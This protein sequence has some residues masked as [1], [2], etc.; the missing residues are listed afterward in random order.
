VTRSNE[1]EEATADFVAGTGA[2]LGTATITARVPDTGAT[3]TAKI[4]IE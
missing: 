1:G 4:T 2:P 3:A